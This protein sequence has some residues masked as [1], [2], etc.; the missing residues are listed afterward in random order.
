MVNIGTLIRKNFLSFLDLVAVTSLLQSDSDGPI[1]PGRPMRE[2][3]T[4][5]GVA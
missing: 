4:G 1:S 2:E 5:V 3:T